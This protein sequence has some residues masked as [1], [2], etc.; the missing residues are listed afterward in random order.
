MLF[1][2]FA[3]E[4]FISTSLPTNPPV[5]IIPYS[6]NPK[7]LIKDSHYNN[8]QRKRRRKEFAYSFSLLSIPVH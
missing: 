6:I 5:K 4:P 7:K 8:F 3:T 1:S 2:N